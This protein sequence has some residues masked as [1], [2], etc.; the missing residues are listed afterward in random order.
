[1]LF[2][3][4]ITSFATLKILDNEFSTVLEMKEN[5]EVACSFFKVERESEVGNFHA[6]FEAFENHILLSS[7]D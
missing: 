3:S 1:M 2:C 7:N 5:I 4:S 6:K